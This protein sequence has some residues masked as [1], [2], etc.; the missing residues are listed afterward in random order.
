MSDDDEPRTV[1]KAI[2][3]GLLDVVRPVVRMIVYAHCWMTGDAKTQN[4]EQ[5]HSKKPF[6]FAPGCD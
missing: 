5:A 6:P 4:V 2:A 1:G 3:V